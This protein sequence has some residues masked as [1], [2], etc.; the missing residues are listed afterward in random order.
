MEDYVK[1][2]QTTIGKWIDE[3]WQ[4]GQA[5]SHEDYQKALAGQFELFLTPT[6]AVPKEW[7]ANLKNKKVLGLA[8]GGGQQGPIL[9]ALGA[10]VTIIDFSP[11]QIASEKAVAQR[12]GYS[13]HAIQGDISQPLPF[14]DHCFDLVVHPVANVYLKEI[15]PIWNEVARILKTG[16]ELLAGLDNGINYIVDE[17]EERVVN[18]LPFNP[19]EN[20]E[21]MK[22]LEKGNDGVQFSH[23]IE[24]QIGGQLK[25]G[26]SLI[27]VYSDTNGIGRLDELNIPTFWA[28]RSRK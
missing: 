23:S 27:D 11:Q 25:A 16:G 20:V 2:N 22:Q 9:T 15:Q 1:K 4:W 14:A 12:E 28:T 21:Q 24:E 5:L 10:E 19:L 26:L 8:S 3:G 7:L 17:K 18:H 13:I 6:V